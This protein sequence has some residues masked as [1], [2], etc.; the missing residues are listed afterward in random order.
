MAKHQGLPQVLPFK[1]RKTLVEKC[2]IAV[3]AINIAEFVL[4]CWY[5]FGHLQ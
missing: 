2:A 4:F 1:R 3:L 5:T